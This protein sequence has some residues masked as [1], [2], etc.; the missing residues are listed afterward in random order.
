MPAG[1]ARDMGG[2]GRRFGPAHGSRCA[3]GRGVKRRGMDTAK[4]SPA[5]RLGAA[6]TVA[7]VRVKAEAGEWT[8]TG[9]WDGF[10][11]E[12]VFLPGDPQMRAGW[13]VT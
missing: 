7:G 2:I 3:P 9:G 1:K 5:L 4:I 10:V 8:R 12:P 6:A 13:K 11:V